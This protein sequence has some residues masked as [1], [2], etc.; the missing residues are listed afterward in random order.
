M[1]LSAVIRLVKHVTPQPG[2][3]KKTD[4]PA[5]LREVTSLGMAMLLGPKFAVLRRA[6][7]LS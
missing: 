5:K 1:K 7:I 6:E 4:Q 3:K 2:G